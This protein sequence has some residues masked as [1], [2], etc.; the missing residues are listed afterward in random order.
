MNPFPGPNPN[1]PPPSPMRTEGEPSYVPPRNDPTHQ[2]IPDMG[3]IDELILTSQRDQE[4]ENSRASRHQSVRQG[5]EAQEAGFEQSEDLRGA[6]GGQVEALAAASYSGSVPPRTRSP[7]G[8]VFT[9][10]IDGCERKF[11]NLGQLKDDEETQ[12]PT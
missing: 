11:E 8:Y 4:E 1:P 7:S 6:S 5:E 2:G 9:C 3:A 12:H 10:S